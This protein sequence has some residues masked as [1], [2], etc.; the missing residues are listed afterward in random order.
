VT[1]NFVTFPPGPQV[2]VKFPVEL[3]K[4]MKYLEEKR[5][6]GLGDVAVTHL[7]IKAVGLALAEVPEVSTGY[8]L[9][10]P[11]ICMQHQV[12]CCA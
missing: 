2:V 12:T 11:V 7:A 4:V 6:A 1:A 9:A 3:R 10:R 5:K 8:D